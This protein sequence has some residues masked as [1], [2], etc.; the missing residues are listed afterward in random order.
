M[1]R[2]AAAW[3]SLRIREPARCAPADVGTENRS[4]AAAREAATAEGGE[5]RMGPVDGVRAERAARGPPGGGILR[6]PARRF[7]PSRPLDCH[8]PDVFHD[9]TPETGMKTIPLFPALALS[10]MLAL[11]SALHAQ[12]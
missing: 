1:M 5:G 4:V 11:P 2:S 10:A 7:K 3:Y 8:M 9:P 12:Q 6:P